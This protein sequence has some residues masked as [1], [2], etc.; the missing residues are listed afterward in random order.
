MGKLKTIIFI[1]LGFILS[2]TVSGQEQLGLTLDNFTGMDQARLNPAFVPSSALTF[3]IRLV[4][5]S[6]FVENNYAFIHNTSILDMKSKTDFVSAFDLDG[7][8]VPN[9]TL[10]G[11]VYDTPNKKFVKFS[12]TIAGPSIMIKIAEKH[13]VGAFVNFRSAFTTNN[14]PSALGYYDYEKQ[15]YLDEF[16]IAPFKAAGANWIETGIHYGIDIERS[17]GRIDFG[18]NLKYNS[19]LES[20]I[21]A[22]QNEMGYTKISKDSILIKSPAIEFGI[23]SGNIDEIVVDPNNKTA[24]IGNLSPKIYGHGLSTDIGASMQIEDNDIE[25]YR[26][27]LGASILDFGIAN[28]TKTAQLHSSSPIPDDV[29]ISF[30]EFDNT[31][32]LD[33]L[34]KQLSDLALGDP[35]ASLKANSFKI[36]LPTAISIQGDYQFIQNVF[37]GATLVQPFGLTRYNL[38][39]T[40]VLAVAPRFE[41]RYFSLSAP[42][43]LRD[44]KSARMG[45]AGRAG[46]LTL[47]TD[48]LGSFIKKKDFT[49][50][51]FYLAIHLSAIEL[52]KFMSSKK[53][54][55]R[56]GKKSKLGCY[57]F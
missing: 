14:I 8:P 2:K 29:I 52:P 57:G 36:G 25:G 33:S 35:N 53:G 44:W 54:K 7:K 37:V 15:A 11:D 51:D 30:S 24:E 13:S 9:N 12:S 31:T 45:L 6:M 43:V 40:A 17:N 16:S 10:V 21:F 3:D 34:E 50:T 41:N 38:T 56:R 22:L 39:R 49:G 1:F 19:F 27:R 55:K 20:G 28:L 23:T 48:N 42:V 18:I 5:L 26:W 46:F 4:G 47:G 32:S